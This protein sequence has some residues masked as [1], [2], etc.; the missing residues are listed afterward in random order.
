MEHN[1]SMFCFYCGRKTELVYKEI[2]KS[3]NQKMVTIHNVPLFHCKDCRE[4]FYPD[5]VIDAF[6]NFAKLDVQTSNC[7]FKSL[8][9]NLSTS[10]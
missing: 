6:N 5:F 8:C 4:V 10:Y 9:F 3:F 1:T 7:D 2:R